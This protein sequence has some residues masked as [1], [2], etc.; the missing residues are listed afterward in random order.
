M[1]DWRLDIA[2][3]RSAQK[4]EWGEIIRRVFW[5]AGAVLFRWTPRLLYGVRNALLR[6]FGAEIGKNVRIHPSAT[7]YFPW[8][9][10]IGDWSSVGENAMIY[11]LGPIEIGEKV[12]VSQRAH[13]CAGTHDATDPAMPLQ[14]PPI[15]VG[16]QAWV[17]ADA[18]VGPGVTVEEG[19]VVGARAVVV[20][21]VEAWTIVGGNPARPLRDREL[22]TG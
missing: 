19:A 9:V 10:S 8:N 5:G 20:K 22:T 15:S 11:N 4:Y 6:L 1:S 7:I 2:E 17:C 13:L 14:K 12:T 18:F 16:D 21:D 3:N